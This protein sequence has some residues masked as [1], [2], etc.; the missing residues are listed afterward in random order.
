[1]PRYLVVDP[2]EGLSWPE[3]VAEDFREAALKYVYGGKDHPDPQEEAEVVAV[4]IMPC[5][6]EFGCGDGAPNFVV[7]DVAALAQ[8]WQM[9]AQDPTE[10]GSQENHG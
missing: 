1:M 5:I 8:I 2:L 6:V 3:V 10:K 9:V 7:I 4:T